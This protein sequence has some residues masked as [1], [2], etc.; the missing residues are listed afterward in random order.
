MSLNIA[1]DIAT[2]VYRVEILDW[3]VVVAA[4]ARGAIVRW[5]TDALKGALVYTV[6]I[7]ALYDVS[8][9]IEL[10]RKTISD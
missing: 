6:D 9:E 2:Q 7:D 5:D 4:F 8:L 1:H 10:I 3:R